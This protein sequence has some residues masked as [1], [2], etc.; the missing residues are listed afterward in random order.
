MSEPD[1]TSSISE[2]RKQR[3]SKMRCCIVP[4]QRS[5][6]CVAGRPYG[7]LLFRAAV[8][9]PLLQMHPGAEEGQVFPGSA[10][11]C[12]IRLCQ[13]RWSSLCEA[14][15]SLSFSTLDIFAGPSCWAL[16][17]SI[18]SLPSRY[19]TTSQLPPFFFFAKTQLLLVIDNKREKK[20][21]MWLQ[22]LHPAVKESKNSIWLSQRQPAKSWWLPLNDLLLNCINNSS[23]CLDLVSSGVWCL[24]SDKSIVLKCWAQIFLSGGKPILGDA[25]LI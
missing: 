24:T 1:T 22:V 18:S 11:N 7:P 16:I 2:F 9:G 25:T 8:G 6:C 17:Q 4:G 19:Y 3:F 13:Q 5:V 20:Y 23:P 21:C 10:G 12:L 14:A 15:G